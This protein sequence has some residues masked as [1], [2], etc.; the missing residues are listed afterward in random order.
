MSAPSSRPSRRSRRHSIAGV[1]KAALSWHVT[2]IDTFIAVHDTEADAI[3]RFGDR[4]R[5]VR[6]VAVL[7]AIVLPWIALALLSRDVLPGA[8]RWLDPLFATTLI[9]TYIGGRL[10]AIAVSQVPRRMTL[11]ALATTIA[12]ILAVAVLEVTAMLGW[13][14]WTLIFKSLSGEGVDYHTAYVRDHELSFRRIPGLRWS[15]RPASD[16]EESYG[17]PRS[18]EHPITFTFDQWGYRN[19][20]EMAHADVVLLGDSMVEGWYVSDAETVAVQLAERIQRPVANLGVA[21]FGTLQQLRVLK[22]DALRRTPKVVAWFF[23]EGNDLYDDQRFTDDLPAMAAERDQ[24][25]GSQS[26]VTR[27]HGWRQR[28]FLLNSYRLIRRCSDPLI[29]TRA[30]YWA[31]LRVAGLPAQRIYFFLYGGVPWTAFEEQRWAI[32]RAALEEGVRLAA[33]HKVKL[34][35]VYVPTKYRV[36]RDFVDVPPGSPM[37][38]WDVWHLLP[39]RF[40]DFCVQAAVPCVDLTH[41]MRQ[42][43]A[44]GRMTHPPNDTHWN[45]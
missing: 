32:A 21:G 26:N 20:A 36:F 27:T 14:H 34:L 42:A 1:G 45:A 28:S 19:L 15:G 13:V 23:F 3:A 5:K 33:D 31:N 44:R 39:R 40:D 37:E 17:L 41:P 43:V 9:A 29:P 38:R 35:F 18:L 4:R 25:D 12:V 16:I 6:A 7:I 8:D 11:R 10:F 2:K 30:P 24:T 22:G